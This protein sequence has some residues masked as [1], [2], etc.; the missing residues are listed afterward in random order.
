MQLK[1]IINK[2]YKNWYNDPYIFEK[3]DNWV[4]ITYGKFIEN[5]LGLANTLINLG[6]KN[7]KIIIISENSTKLME[8][9]LAISF[10]V[11]ISA[12]VSRE[13]KTKD[14]LA[15]IKE[16]KANLL[17]YSSKY[18]EIIDE[19]KTKSKIETLCIDE[20]KPIFHKGQLDWKIKTQNKT[21]KIVFSSGTTGK[22]KAVK[23]SLKNVF[24]G[25]NSLQRR[26][27]LNH[28]DSAYLFLPLN[29]TYAAVYNF[30]Y[31]L[32][33]GYSLYLASSTTNI[34]QE[35]LETNPTVFCAVPLVFN[36]L[37]DGYKEKIP[38]AFGKN[39]KYLFCGG[40]P[41]SKE[42]RQ[43]Y[44][45]AGLNLMQAYA[46]SETASSLTIAYPYSD[47]LESVGAIFEDIDVKIYE[48]D[49]DGVGE[50]IVKG[51]NVFLG[52][53]DPSLTKRVFDSNGYFHTGDLGLIKDG[54]IYLKGRKKK[55]LLTSNGENVMAEEI[56]EGIKT[57]N[58]H[59]KDVKAYIKKDV[60]N[61]DVYV[62]EEINL[63]KIIDTY[64]KDV[65]KYEK[66]VKYNM[67]KDSLD[68]RLKQ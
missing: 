23:L 7:K 45:D 13:W 39:I 57:L 60:I 34:A 3:H 4:P 43:I 55:M 54:K 64:N 61:V 2:N 26:C 56:E 31:S 58:E 16:L 6:Y 24:A 51:D 19:V 30:M 68:T 44:K 25:Y 12:V 38:Y 22:S 10:Y 14:I 66:V 42:T 27:N 36:R 29:H 50:I 46:L 48:P 41:I 32:I 59:I 28:T 47:D 35:L 37:L 53:T 8:L 15:G 62:D 40:A 52:Y 17:I 49:N 21:A 20:I 33:G 5:S 67:Y 9:D 18:K 11:G 63:K 1:R 65:P